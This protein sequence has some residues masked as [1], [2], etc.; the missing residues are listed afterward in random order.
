MPQFSRSSLFAILLTIGLPLLVGASDFPPLP[1]VSPQQH[2]APPLPAHQSPRVNV[3]RSSSTPVRKGQSTGQ[4]VSPVAIG[5]PQSG[6]PSAPASRQQTRLTPVTLSA[7]GPTM[8][9]SDANQDREP[10]ITTVRNGV[11]H[12]EVQ[13]AAWIQFDPTNA[14]THIS[15][16]SNT[17]GG[18]SSAV[19]LQGPR[20]NAGDPML[21]PNNYVGGFNPQTVYCVA[22]S[23]NPGTGTSGVS[24]NGLLVWQNS[25]S[26]WTYQQVESHTGTNYFQGG[27]VIEDRW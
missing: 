1:A 14:N 9:N 18:W 12:T 25:G 6:V 5:S 23:S 26:G 22:N 21:S 17:G 27:V 4:N 3:K 13:Y 11:T 2:A 24:D 16:S 20:A 15:A 7:S 10:T 8:I 19:T